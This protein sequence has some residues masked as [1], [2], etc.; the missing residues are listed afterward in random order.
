MRFASSHAGGGGA[1]GGPEPPHSPSL[2]GPWSRPS[3]EKKKTLLS[4]GLPLLVEAG[5]VEPPSRNPTAWALRAYP[6][7]SFS[8]PVCPAEGSP[9]A[10]PD[11]VSLGLYGSPASASPLHDA[12]SPAAGTPGRDG[13]L[14]L[15]GQGQLAVGVY[16]FSRLLT[17][18]GPPARS[19]RGRRSLSKPFR[20]LGF[21][22]SLL[23]FSSIALAYI[24]YLRLARKAL[25]ARPAGSAGPA[26][27]SFRLF[28]P[29]RPPRTAGQRGREGP[30]IAG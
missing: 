6:P 27:R 3:S 11:Q 19:H 9:G 1:G 25:P 5:G 28:G 22:A 7:I 16:L 13:P 18:R 14:I 4:K 21:Q 8:L 17:G 2:P 26:G 29:S 10:I 24:F 20:P 12:P 23:P 15:S 30:D